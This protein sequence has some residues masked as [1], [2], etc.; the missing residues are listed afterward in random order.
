VNPFRADRFWHW[1]TLIHDLV[2]R[3]TGRVVL[4]VDDH[5]SDDDLGNEATYRWADY[6]REVFWPAQERFIAAL[7]R[8]EAA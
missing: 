7:R 2:Y 8:K 1:P 6:E 3:L 5:P 4:R